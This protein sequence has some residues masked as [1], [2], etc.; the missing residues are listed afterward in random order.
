MIKILLTLFIFSTRVFAVDVTLT[1]QYSDLYKSNLIDFNINNENEKSLYCRK[2]YLP[3]VNYLVDDEVYDFMDI[4]IKDIFVA[5]N[6]LKKVTQDVGDELLSLLK[7][8][9]NI[10]IDIN[11][12][13]LIKDCEYQKSK[14]NNIYVVDV[15]NGKRS[16]KR[17]P[18]DYGNNTVDLEDKVTLVQNMA[19]TRF[20]KSP[21][22][23][24]FFL[25]KSEKLFLKKKLGDNDLT[26]IREYSP[27]QYFYFL[28]GFWVDK[29]NFIIFSVEKE[30]LL[31]SN[32]EYI[33]E[34]K[35]KSSKK[36]V[37]N[38]YLTKENETQVSKLKILTAILEN[39]EKFS[40]SIILYYKYN[41]LF[42]KLDLAISRRLPQ[43]DVIYTKFD[44]NKKN[45]NGE[46]GEW[47]N[48]VYSVSNFS[49]SMKISHSHVQM[50]VGKETHI[51]Y[52][53]FLDTKSFRHLIRNQMMVRATSMY[54]TIKHK[55]IKIRFNSKELNITMGKEKKSINGCNIEQVFTDKIIPGSIGNINKKYKGQTA[56]IKSIKDRNYKKFSKLLS[57]GA[58]PDERDFLDNA[59]LHH[60]ILLDK[61]SYLQSLLM[62]NADVNIKD[63][64]GNTVLHK[65]FSRIQFLKSNNPRL[66]YRKK[67]LL[68]I[69][70]E[71]IKLIFMH[72]FNV[73]IKNKNGDSMYEILER[74][75]MLKDIESLVGRRLL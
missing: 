10:N 23:S 58:N 31:V 9:T 46:N 40:K 53:S 72:N 49:S 51:D 6:E 30:S 19:K 39:H 27:G 47:V 68:K 75:G 5:G 41:H 62:N 38:R 63:Y 8:S 14:M 25:L 26:F 22:G 15:C 11:K 55:N 44:E 3:D 45:A 24:E 37:L 29:N 74:L 1:K 32:Y 36:I 60:S 35:L 34:V 54:K 69:Y 20:Y 7:I 66:K 48:P 21:F 71:H 57:A 56:L 67:S 65:I 18:I 13:E 2:I 52:T 70:S 28:G 43:W 42:K 12:D 16:L 4:G 33:D 59:A 64:Q 61:T 50:N 73:R 17:Y